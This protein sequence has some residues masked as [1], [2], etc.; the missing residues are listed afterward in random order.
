[1][2]SVRY[3]VFMPALMW[4][5]IR[6]PPPGGPDRVYKMFEEQRQESRGPEGVYPQ[7]AE[8]PGSGLE[9]HVRS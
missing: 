3:L 2:E 4:A 1:M 7:P 9:L 8:K 6:L 5:E